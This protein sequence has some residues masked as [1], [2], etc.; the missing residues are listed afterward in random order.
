MN[1]RY[2]V[3][4]SDEAKDIF[5]FIQIKH[6]VPASPS[7]L[8]QLLTSPSPLHSVNQRD[9]LMTALRSML[10]NKEHLLAVVDDQ[11]R[12]VGIVTLEDIAGEL[13]SADIDTF[14]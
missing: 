1:P 4:R 5:G 14:R 10:Q 3:S 6:A 13:L 9:T 8:E 11:K 2:P 7:E 12:C